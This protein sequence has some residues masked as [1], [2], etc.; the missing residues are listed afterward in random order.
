FRS[1]KYPRGVFEVQ[2]WVED[3]SETTLIMFMDQSAGPGRGRREKVGGWTKTW[4]LSLGKALADPEFKDLAEAYK[5]K[6][7]ELIRSYL[8]NGVLE[9]DEL[10]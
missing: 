6:L 4:E 10:S 5:M 7:V 3:P 8:E 1:N 9:L 2:P